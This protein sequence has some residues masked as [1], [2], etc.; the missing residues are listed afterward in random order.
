MPPF[1]RLLPPLLPR[2]LLYNHSG[3][4]RREI[5]PIQIQPTPIIHHNPLYAICSLVLL[6]LFFLFQQCFVSRQAVGVGRV[7]TNSRS[8]RWALRRPARC[9]APPLAQAL[10]L[11]LRLG[12]FAPPADPIF[13]PRII[14][15]GNESINNSR[16][17]TPRRRGAAPPGEARRSVAGGA[18]PRHERIARVE[19]LF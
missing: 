1:P 8:W 3:L 5:Q 6:N 11:G 16:K 7:G 15:D 13:D 17:N 18:T 10:V 4:L 9:S 14:Y 12:G 19:H 2:L